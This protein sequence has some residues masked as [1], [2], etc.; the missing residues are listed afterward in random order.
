MP[1]LPAFTWRN[2]TRLGQDPCA[3]WVEVR[4]SHSGMLLRPE[5]YTALGAHL[6]RWEGSHSVPVT[7]R[8]DSE[9][10]AST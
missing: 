4:S 9:L 3:E 8:P 7:G 10:G 5:F 2:R 6:S 1:R